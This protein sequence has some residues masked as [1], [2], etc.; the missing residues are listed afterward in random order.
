MKMKIKLSQGELTEPLCAVFLTLVRD[1]SFV[2]STSSIAIKL[3]IK[4]GDSK[5]QIKAN[6]LCK[7]LY[8]NIHGIDR[9]IDA[10]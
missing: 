5:I 9:E 8:V 2:K 4:N 10:R 6:F 7:A 1:Y 3:S